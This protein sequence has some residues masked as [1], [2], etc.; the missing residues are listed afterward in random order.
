MGAYK[1]EEAVTTHP[2]VIKAV[3]KIFP[4]SKTFGRY[5]LGFLDENKTHEVDVLA[6]AFMLLRKTTLDKVGL[7]DE[8][9]FMYGEDLDWCKRFR[10]AGYTVLYYPLVA[11]THHKYKS[12]IKSL[13]GP[14]V[15]KT[16][17]HFYDTMHQYFEKHHAKNYPAWVNRLVRYFIKIK[18]MQKGV[19]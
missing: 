17:K 8:T 7:L 1:P 6:G 4:K 12:G 19:E 16:T 11:I 15:N 10:D 18:K 3:C 14:T 2:S 9:F 13:S 5:H